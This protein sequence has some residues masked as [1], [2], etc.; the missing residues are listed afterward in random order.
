MEEFEKI[1]KD[2]GWIVAWLPPSHLSN[3]DEVAISINGGMYVLTRRRKES[4]SQ[5][6]N[7]LIKYILENNKSIVASDKTSAIIMARRS[8]SI[9]ML[10]QHKHR[11]VMQVDETF[12]KNLFCVDKVLYWMSIRENN[13]NENPFPIGR[14]IM[15]GILNLVHA[16]HSFIEV[17]IDESEMDTVTTILTSLAIPYTIN[18]QTR[19]IEIE[20]ILK[21]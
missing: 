2:Q 3:E 8:Y 4:V 19:G 16:R 6:R 7:R 20:T 21:K 5:T 9:P 10:Q 14:I 13:V 1:A 12:T 17:Y 11:I 15:T 18:E